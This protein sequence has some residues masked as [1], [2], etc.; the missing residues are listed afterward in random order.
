MK[1]VGPVTIRLVDA[2]TLLA[3]DLAVRVDSVLCNVGGDQS[4]TRREVTVPGSSIAGLEFATMREVNPHW[5]AIGFGAGYLGTAALWRESGRDLS[6]AL[7]GLFGG[8]IVAGVCSFLPP[9]SL[10]QDHEIECH[11]A[12]R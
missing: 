10:E 9:L 6:A 2:D 7:V 8:I 4:L 5:S 11:G 1:P 12:R 3:F